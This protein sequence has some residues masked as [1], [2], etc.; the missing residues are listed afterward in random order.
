[1][2]GKPVT[3]SDSLAY[4]IAEAVLASVAKRPVLIRQATLERR[5]GKEKGDGYQMSVKGLYGVP[6]LV[7]EFS[8]LCPVLDRIP[9]E[10]QRV[11]LGTSEGG[12][13]G[14]VCAKRRGRGFKFEFRKT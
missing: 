10:D 7:G 1:M 4:K 11:W 8:F 5:V 2:R 13:D 9:W 6:E 14:V 12:T 3:F